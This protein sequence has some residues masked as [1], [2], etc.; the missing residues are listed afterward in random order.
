MFGSIS[1]SGSTLAL[2]GT[3]GVGNANFILL[4]ASNLATPLNNWTPLSTNPFDAGG[5]FA[6]TNSVDSNQPQMFYLLK[7]P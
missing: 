2:S 6:I 1:I 7:L 5:N 4:G 3:G